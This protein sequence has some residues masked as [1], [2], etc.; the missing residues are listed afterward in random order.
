M[1]GGEGAVIFG[2]GVVWLRHL[3]AAHGLSTGS[4]TIAL[5][6]LVLGVGLGMIVSPLFDFILATVDDDGSAPR[7]EF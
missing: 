3:I 1:R 4:L 7:P 2:V 5:A 6:E